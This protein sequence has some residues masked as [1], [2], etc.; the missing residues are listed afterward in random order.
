LDASASEARAVTAFSLMIEI[1]VDIK[2]V[3]LGIIASI[4]YA[5]IF[6]GVLSRKLVRAAQA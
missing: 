3:S 2:V 5:A 1:P 4:Y 6:S